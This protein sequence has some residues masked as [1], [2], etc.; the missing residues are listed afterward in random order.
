MRGDGAKSACAGEGGDP[1]FR[2]RGARRQEDADGGE[3][4][5]VACVGNGAWGML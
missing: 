2:G 5:R 1:A 3:R 4:K